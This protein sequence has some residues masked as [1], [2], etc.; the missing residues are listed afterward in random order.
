M[1]PNAEERAWERL[2]KPVPRGRYEHPSVYTLRTR[3]RVNFV[4]RIN[5]KP[6]A[7]WLWTGAFVTV[8]NAKLP[9]YYHNRDAKRTP[10][11]NTTRS[12]FLWMMREW[13]PEVPTQKWAKTDATCGNDLCI[14]PYH[15][16]HKKL[17]NVAEPFRINHDQIRQVYALRDSG[18][19]V[20]EVAREFGWHNTLVSKIWSGARYA[21]VTGHPNPK[22]KRKALSAEAAVQVYARLD[23]N[24]NAQQVADE[25]GVSVNVV[26]DIWDGY[27]HS[28]ATGADPKGRTRFLSEEAY[29][30]IVG[31]YNSGRASRTVAV[32]AKVSHNTVVRVWKKLA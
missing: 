20:N 30:I 28:A 31:A 11:D 27:R 7:C 26:R 2:Q 21:G 5:R 13:F 8:A 22:P 14:S 17:G 9:M 6:G 24:A 15:R 4:R 18:R 32:E 29:Q 25:F 19:G 1:A 3:K 16:Q 12:A 23:S 10:N